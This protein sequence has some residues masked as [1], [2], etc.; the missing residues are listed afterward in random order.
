[1]NKLL[2]VCEVNKSAA[3][4]KRDQAMLCLLLDLKLAC[5]RIA[6]LRYRD[7]SGI[8]EGT[9]NGIYRF[10]AKTNAP[11][12]AIKCHPRTAHAIRVW[13]DETKRSFRWEADPN[14]P[15][16]VPLSLINTDARRLQ[17]TPLKRDAV[18]KVFAA[19]KS[20]SG[21]SLSREVVNRTSFSDLLV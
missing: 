14:A 11:T 10:N 19:L 7:V 21:V 2:Q 12:R 3:K 1:M 9:F 8:L 18:S 4:A 5:Q 17:R 20:A 16:F 6:D 15:L 13:A